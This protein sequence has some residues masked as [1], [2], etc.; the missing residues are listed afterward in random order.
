MLKDDMSNEAKLNVNLLDELALFKGDLPSMSALKSS[1]IAEANSTQQ[2][3]VNH[4]IKPVSGKT[5]WAY[6]RSFRWSFAVTA[7]VLLAISVVLVEPLQLS[8]QN[9]ASVNV[10]KNT[11]TF[12]DLDLE[13]EWQALMLN[14]D[15]FLFGEVSLN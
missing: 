2:Q 8:P 15:E 3:S 10:A 13:L 12:S 14:E 6:F 9:S 11:T 5:P 7:V 1:I 4:H